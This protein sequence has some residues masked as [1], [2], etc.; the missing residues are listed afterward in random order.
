MKKII[1]GKKYD[2]GT[3][4]CVGTDGYSRAGDFHR[5]TEKLYQ[6]NSGVFFLCGEGGP[7]SHYGRRDGQNGFIG[8][9]KVI[10]YTIEEAKEWV[11]KHLDAD[12]YEEIFGEVEE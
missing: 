2:T 11:E 12:E 1:G 5:W 6:K 9:E 7:L 3:A 8:G 4:H 10:P